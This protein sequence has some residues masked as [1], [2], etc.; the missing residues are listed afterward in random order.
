MPKRNLLD[1]YKK[2]IKEKKMT[3]VVFVTLR[4][5][6]VIAAVHSYIVGTYENLFFC[7]LTFVL[8]TLPSFIER[9]FGIE[10]PSVLEIIILLF[11]FA[12][13][14][15][16]E[17]GSYYT[18]VPYWDSILH[19]VNGFLCAAIGFALSDILNRNEK[20]K[21]RLSPVFLSIVAFCFSMTIGVLW[22]FF[23]FIC[24]VFFKTDM[25]KDYVVGFISSTLLGNGTK[26]PMIINDIKNTVA[27]GTRL[28]IDGYLDIG[29]YD[30]MKDLFVNF[31]GATFFSIIGFFYVKKRG[32]GRFANLF[33]PKLKK[34]GNIEHEKK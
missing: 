12:A 28:N 6:V 20:I 22:E 15:L 7:V 9:N 2:T 32:K 33:I 31:I 5:L 34:K 14:I 3:F 11:I 23:E 18:K 27:N 29:L 16:G 1:A 13:E 17:M 21:F 25:Q 24:D 19:T 26:E 4:I 30:T 10:L 8:L